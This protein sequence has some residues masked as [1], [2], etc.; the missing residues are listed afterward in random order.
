M[1]RFSPSEHPDFR[2]LREAG[3]PVNDRPHYLRKEVVQALKSMYDG[4]RQDHPDIPFTVVSTT[5]P[6]NHQKAIWS[7]KWEGRSPVSGRLLPAE[8]DNPLQRA[9]KILEYSSMPG[10]SR[11]HW[12]TDFDINTLQNEYYDSYPGSVVY[13]WLKDN[14]AS[15]GF[16]QPYTAGRDG[17]YNEEK[18]HWSYRPLAAPM[19]ADWIRLFGE[20]IQG[21]FPGS[22]VALPLSREYVETVDPACK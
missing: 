8:V 10:T 1:G 16:C 18:W 19:L 11:H 6:Y 9:R 7:A 2:A 17:G 21:D 20:E 3:I 12:G 14:A 13:G 4:F 22:E 15:Y 5:R